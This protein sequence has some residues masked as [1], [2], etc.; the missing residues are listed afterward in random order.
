MPEKLKADICII[1]GGPGGIA[2]ASLAA[3]M[4]AEVVLVEKGLMG[5]NRLNTGCVP[6]HAFIEAARMAHEA[7]RASAF[8]VVAKSKIDFAAVNRHV[9][10]IAAKLAPNDS[11]SR[12]EAQGVRVIKAA[13]KFKDHRT[14]LA[15]EFEIRGRAIVIA[16]GARATLPSIAGLSDVPW[17]THETIFE[18]QE[19]PDHLIVLGAGTTGLELAQAH[20]RLG[21]RVT[22]VETARMLGREDAELAAM[23]GDCLRR[24]GIEILEGVNVT[25]L[26]RKGEKIRVSI[27]QHG[28]A[29]DID[30][31][32][33]LIATGR[34]A[35]VDGMEL[36]KAGIRYNRRGIR[37]NAHQRTS[38]RRIYAVGD[39]TGGDAS[40]HAAQHQAGVVV[41]NVLFRLPVRALPEALPRVVYT[42]PEFAHLGE[43]EEQARA[44]HVKVNVLRAPLADNDR[45]QTMRDTQGGI[46][47]VTDLH[48][49]LLGVSILA[50]N[51]ADL[52]LPWS[53]AKAQGLK[54]GSIA[55]AIAPYPTLSE[56]STRVAASY[57]TQTLIGARTR[58]LVRF[59][60]IF[61][62]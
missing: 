43:T 26:A 42:S 49:R 45:A 53:I 23:L 44:R 24:E 39:V 17:F 8:G 41:R 29:R 2:V 30:G 21:A 34:A 46:K 25:H 60:R 12:L 15:G 32:H 55:N 27:E 61:G 3:Q 6:S 9:K 19:R 5:G 47:L 48:G 20:A 37:V 4:G 58:K 56:L 50:P 40:T 57:F 22:L 13:A 7:R 1:G 62:W 11:L 14:V 18:N 52:I 35:N 16:T 31:T 54:L 33:L 36:E 59:L 51:A 28:E 10:E 38:N